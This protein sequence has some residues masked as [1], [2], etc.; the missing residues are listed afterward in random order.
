MYC[1]K[2][3]KD[4]TFAVLTLTIVI[5]FLGPSSVT[6]FQFL[7]PSAGKATNRWR[8]GKFCTFR[9]V[10]RYILEKVE[11]VIVARSNIELC[12]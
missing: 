4:Q 6:K 2:T 7:A 10:F 12:Q 1:I 3:T 8:V 11:E 9:P 5:V